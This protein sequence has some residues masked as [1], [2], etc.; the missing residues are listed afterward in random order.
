MLDHTVLIL[1]Q[2]YFYL[3]SVVKILFAHLKG[4]DE[5]Y[6]DFVKKLVWYKLID[7]TIDQLFHLM[8]I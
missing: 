1:N 2:I 5:L 3:Y 6:N 7:E 4:I 8:F